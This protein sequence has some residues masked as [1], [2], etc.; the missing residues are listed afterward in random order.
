MSNLD[1]VVNP[2]SEHPL[3]SSEVAHPVSVAVRAVMQRWARVTE[4]MQLQR[5]AAAENVSVALAGGGDGERERDILAQLQAVHAAAHQRAAAAM[6]A[7]QIRTTKLQADIDAV[8]VAGDAAYSA[9]VDRGDYI[10]AETIWR[11]GFR[12]GEVLTT[13]CRADVLEL[14]EAADFGASLRG[15]GDL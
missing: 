4:D 15:A 5:A 8:A 2:P 11:E 13:E 14:L 12:A 6:A 3:V 7:V 1:E 10:G 9:A